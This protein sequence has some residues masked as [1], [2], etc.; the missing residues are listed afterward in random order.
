M[1]NK[2]TGKKK[3]FVLFGICSL[4][5]LVLCMATLVVTVKNIEGE[6]SSS[7]NMQVNSESKTQL[8]GETN[9]LTEYI[10]DL[11][12]QAE[13]NKFIKVN[14]Y[15]DVSIDD[16]S[17]IVT[18][19]NG[20]SKDNDKNIFTYAKKYF[21]SLV[22]EIYGDDVTGVFGENTGIKPLVEFS[23]VDSL[24]SAFSVGQVDENGENLLNEDGTVVDG[25]FYFI[26]FEIDGKSVIDNKE[27][28]TFCVEDL[29][30]K[31]KEIK[32]Q[33]DK[34]CEINGV[35]VTP[36]SFFVNAKVNRFTDK[37]EYIEI[38]RNY[39]V[40]GN[41]NFIDSLSAFGEKNIVFNYSV[42]HRFEYFYAGVDIAESEITIA[43]GKESAVTVNAVIEDYS[44]YTVRFISSDESIATVDE[45][46]YVK[47]VKTSEK[48]V[49][50]TVELEYLGETFTDEC[51]VYIND[52]KTSGE[53]A[54]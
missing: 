36:E 30:E 23:S 10:Y 2:K 20:N 7:V 11:T 8:S 3:Q 22:D 13:N 25:D 35:N 1:N 14:S 48:P 19:K 33:I 39:T 41:Y 24:T 17:V 21:I 42:T 47:G 53:V 28:T 9:D 43:E 5:A 37:I 54:Q 27:K 16:G 50:I 34:Y 4:L 15:T 44:D 12:K 52:G 51:V 32:S 26:T 29:R 31:T 18:D 49:T 46:G 6:S 38:K 40:S 45:M